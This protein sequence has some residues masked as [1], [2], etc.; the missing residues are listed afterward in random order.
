M[1]LPGP[2]EGEAVG[3]LPTAVS[4]FASLAEMETTS[5]RRRTTVAEARGK[6]QRRPAVIEPFPFDLAN[7]GVVKIVALR[8]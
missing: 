2:A 4:F 8:D 5:A 6:S 1:H 7:L 3:S